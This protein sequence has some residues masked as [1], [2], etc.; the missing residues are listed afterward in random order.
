MWRAAM[1]VGYL[2]DGVPPVGLEFSDLIRI[3]GIGG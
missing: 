2:S 1:H 3:R